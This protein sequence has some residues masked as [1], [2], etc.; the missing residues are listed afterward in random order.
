LLKENLPVIQTPVLLDR[1]RR[2]ESRTQLDDAI[3]ERE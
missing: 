1:G 3:C 2:S